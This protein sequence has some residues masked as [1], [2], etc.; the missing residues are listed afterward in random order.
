MNYIKTVIISIIIVILV[1]NM[2]IMQL[3]IFVPT[4]LI[5]TATYENVM[6][7][8][9]FY[10]QIRQFALKMIKDN[11]QFGESGMPYLKEA[12][13][14]EFLETNISEL[15]NGV[16][17]FIVGD[18]SSLPI[19]PMYKLKDKVYEIY[20][21]G[22]NDEK[23]RDIID[24][25]FNPLPD[26]IR[27]SYI[28]STDAFW[29]VRTIASN[30]NLLIFIC[31]LIM[32]ILTIVLILFSEDIWHGLLWAGSSI[33][34]SAGIVIGIGLIIIWLGG[35]SEL[36]RSFSASAVNYGFPGSSITNLLKALGK[37][38]GIKLNMVAIIF[39]G[40]GSL[41]INFVPVKESTDSED[42]T[43]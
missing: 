16:R 29:F 20:D 25:W 21:N 42:L 19:I 18:E 31:M 39:F 8:Q 30:I 15:L 3:L 7:E 43:E 14:E 1:L 28:M 37:E 4:T 24:Y 26:D 35:Y 27:F 36:S 23:N 34:A 13:T 5:Q 40:L 32:L 33:T 10:G 6:A 2:V 9:H 11:L 22:A 17:Q 12:L 38:L 41:L